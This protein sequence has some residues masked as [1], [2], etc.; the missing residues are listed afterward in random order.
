MI[1][2]KKLVLSIV[3][4]IAIIFPAVSAVVLREDMVDLNKTIS[5]ADLGMTGQ[6]DVQI[7]VGSELVE[8][9]N[10]SGADVLY[11]PLEDYTTVIRPTLTNRWLNNPAMML[12]DAVG[13]L[14]SFALP[15][16]IILG[17]GAVLIGLA[18][19]GRRR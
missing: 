19:V 8:Y 16:F 10:T 14:T 2:N 3:F 4:L 18:N 15:I 17:L 9:G 1:P 5:Y 11:Q 7:W 6:Q 13:Y 12:V